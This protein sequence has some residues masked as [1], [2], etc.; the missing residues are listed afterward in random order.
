MEMETKKRKPAWGDIGWFAA[1]AGLVLLPNFVDLRFD[2]DWSPEYSATISRLLPSYVAAC[3]VVAV[4][5]VFAGL[6]KFPKYTA[7]IAAGA[8]VLVL[9]GGFVQLKIVRE[10]ETR[11]AR[12][13]EANLRADEILSLRDVPADRLEDEARARLRKIAVSMFG[14]SMAGDMFLKPFQTLPS[15][16]KASR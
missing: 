3:L 10:A 4:I 14:E 15:E 9:T 11:Q 7:F 2:G 1:T 8:T 16:E 12:V 6:R 5:A 13:E